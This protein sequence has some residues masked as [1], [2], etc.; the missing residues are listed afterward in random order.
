MSAPTTDTDTDQLLDRITAA[1]SGRSDD[2]GIR[3]TASYEPAGGPGSLVF[4]PTYPPL[5]G[6]RDE[7]KYALSSRHVDGDLR[8]TVL[9][10]SFQSQANRVEQEL[11]DAIDDGIL[12]LPY[13]ETSGRVGDHRVRV[14]NLD[15]PH[16]GPDAYFRDSEDENGVA[17]DDT[18][19][20]R[21]LRVADVRDAR[22]FFQY[23]PTDLVFGF[24]DSQRGGRGVKLA[25][26]YVSEVIGLDP[27]VG[28]RGAV[29]FDPN[30]ITRVPIAFPPKRPDEFVVLEVADDGKTEKAPKGFDTAVPSE[31]GHGNVPAKDPNPGVSVTAINRTA[32][33][34]LTALSRLRFPDADGTISPE[35]D[36]AARAVLACLAL[37]GDQMAFDRPSVF[38]R[39]GCDLV[40]LS[41]EMRWVGR[42]G[43]RDV[44]E[45]ASGDAISL[46]E[47]AVERAAKLGLSWSTEPVRLRPKRNLASLLEAAFS[48]MAAEDD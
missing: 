21:A 40:T 45:L 48:T 26:G 11:K 7:N 14:T 5:N 46:L 41:T 30:N 16:R 43:A 15:A 12:Q 29:R 10:D 8:S 9:I 37:V 23:V 38:L 17:F 18:E 44:I 19:V 2:A 36:A 33:I 31:A 22:A 28:K 27:Q 34:S 24:W 20:G 4:P 39:S 13:I 6:Q 3:I 25:R 42:G 47:L 35:G 32:F 1:C